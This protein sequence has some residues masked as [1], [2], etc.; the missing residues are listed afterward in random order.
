MWYC[1]LHSF[2][3]FLCL[4]GLLWFLANYRN[5]SS[6]SWYTCVPFCFFFFLYI[7]Y[8]FLICGY[9][10]VHISFPGGA[11]GKEPACQFRRYKRRWFIPWV[12][13]IPWR[14]KWQ[15]TPVFLPGES[16]GQR[17]LEGYSPWG[18]RELDTTEVTENTWD[19]YM[20]IYNN[21]Y[22]F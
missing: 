11:T 5:I 21:I 20:L 3:R 13:K 10:G 22:L 7:Y 18:C 2:S 1:Q 8:R 15:P 6:S 14:R 4:F 12:R 16:C 19:L 17:S 9:Y